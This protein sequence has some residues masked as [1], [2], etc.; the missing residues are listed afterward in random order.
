VRLSSS[1]HPR[2]TIADGLVGVLLLYGIQQA[3]PPKSAPATPAAVVSDRLCNALDGLSSAD[4]TTP[5]GKV[6]DW[7]GT[8]TTEGENHPAAVEVLLGILPEDSRLYLERSRSQ[9]HMIRGGVL[10]TLAQVG[11]S[12]KVLR[13]IRAELAT[14]DDPFVFGAACRVA[15]SLGPRAA[16]TV[17]DLERAFGPD[18]MDHTFS[19]R[20]FHQRSP[21][22]EPTTAKLEAVSALRSIGPTA[23]KALPI[24]VEV[25]EGRVAYA[26]KSEELRKA[27]RLAIREISVRAD[28]KDIPC[29]GR[30]SPDEATFTGW[31]AADRRSDPD[32]GSVTLCDQD[33]REF[34]ISDLRGKP[35]FLSFFYTKCDNMRKCSRTVSAAR[36]FRD[37]VAKAGLKARAQIVLVSLDPLY[38]DP[39][40]LREYARARGFLAD[41]H[42]CVARTSPADLE[43]VCRRLEL[44]V[45]FEGGRVNIHGIAA[46]LLDSAGRLARTYHSVT[47]DDDQVVKDL[48][49]LLDD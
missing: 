37:R 23:A 40:R 27:A 20:D 48:E 12:A 22:L 29:D 2:M 4:G 17:P 35:A 9:A 26:E 3:R 31:R 30:D 33:G 28:A 42:A 39:L 1:A 15:A 32:I 5:F 36:A 16:G 7:L 14:S 6:C 43:R 41:R 49:R 46:V 24:L 34:R 21:L 11:P 38:D 45:N 47:W 13:S 8:V 44:P 25:A 18:V 19:L 10:A